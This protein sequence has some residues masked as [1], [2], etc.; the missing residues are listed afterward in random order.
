MSCFLDVLL[1]YFVA[2]FTLYQLE[3]KRQYKKFKVKQ[4]QVYTN[5]FYYLENGLPAWLVALMNSYIL[6][7]ASWFV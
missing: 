2:L 5:S 6:M 7:L 1:E 4:V 3:G